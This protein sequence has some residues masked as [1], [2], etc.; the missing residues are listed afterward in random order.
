MFSLYSLMQHITFA[1]VLDKVQYTNLDD[2]LTYIHK[3]ILRSVTIEELAKIA[4]MEKNYFI[5]FFK[6]HMTK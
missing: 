5:K 4:Y 3:N 2:V 1:F 6:K